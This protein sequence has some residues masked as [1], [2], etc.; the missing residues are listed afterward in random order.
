MIGLLNIVVLWCW[1]VVP[2]WSRETINGVNDL[3]D[4]FTTTGGN[5]GRL[6]VEGHHFHMVF[7]SERV[8]SHYTSHNE[9]NKAIENVQQS[10]Q[11]RLNDHTP[12][13][14]T[15]RSLSS[16]EKIPYDDEMSYL[17]CVLYINGPQAKESLMKVYGY[18]HVSTVHVSHSDN[19]VCF[20]VSTS[21]SRLQQVMEGRTSNIHVQNN[22]FSSGNVNTL[23]LQLFSHL[24]FMY[25]KNMCC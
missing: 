25:V 9:F 2:V 7:G 22:H 4:E 21:R 12:Q 14:S 16:T 1:C 15:R 13:S 17:A 6:S 19:R 23:D 18:S 11:Y 24:D 10:S 8:N 5:G 20:L 3:L